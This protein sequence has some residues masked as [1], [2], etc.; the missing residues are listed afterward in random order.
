M[1]R[2]ERYSPV[3]ARARDLD[4]GIE[5]NQCLREVARVGG[6]AAVADAEHGVTA[7]ESLHR[8]ATGA[9]IALVTF[10]IGGV[11]KIGAAGALQDIAAKARH[12]AKLRAGRLLQ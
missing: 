10:L 12:I 5:R 1:Q 8:R 3:A 4:A 9:G 11:A 7:I 2:R 6:D